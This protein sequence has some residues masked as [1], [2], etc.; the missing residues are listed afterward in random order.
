MST[1]TKNYSEMSWKTLR[2]DLFV[3]LILIG[4]V[5]I[6]NLIVKRILF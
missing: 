1:K 6:A 3:R 2:K 5:V 4:L